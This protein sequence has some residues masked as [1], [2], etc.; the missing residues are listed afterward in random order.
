[1]WVTCNGKKATIVDIDP[2][3]G[4]V[5]ENPQYGPADEVRALLVSGTRKSDVRVRCDKGRPAP[6]I[7]ETPR[8]PGPG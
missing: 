1:L 7:K 2:A 6:T 8:G 5:V 4:Y 3:A